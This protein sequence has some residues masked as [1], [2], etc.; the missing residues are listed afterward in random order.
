MALITRL[1]RLM[2]ADLNAVLD[3]LEEPELLLRQAVRDMEEELERERRDLAHAE[4]EAERLARRRAGL[5]TTLERLDGE[6]ALCLDAD[7][8][9]LARSLV[10]RQLETRALDETLAERLETLAASRDEARE[11][12]A[13]RRRR[14]EDLRQKAELFAAAQ[15]DEV[16]AADPTESGTTTVSAEAVEVALLRARREHDRRSGGES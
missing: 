2:R 7:S 5:A 6:L 1:T 3:R 10:R 9:D 14:L 4:A 15:P 13:E 11:R 8:E 16:D 12:L